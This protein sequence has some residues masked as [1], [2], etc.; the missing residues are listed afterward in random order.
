MKISN[1]PQSVDVRVLYTEGCSATPATVDLINNVAAEMEIE[2]S[3]Q[4]ILVEAPEQAS[5]LK[6]LG[7]PTVQVNSLDIDPAAR[8][9]VDY[10]FM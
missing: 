5:G 8:T 3:L 7:S 9:N 2:I 6:F 1:T 4:S 10:G